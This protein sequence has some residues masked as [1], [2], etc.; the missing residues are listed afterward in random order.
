[1]AAGVRSLKKL[2]CECHYMGLQL[3]R[4]QFV[5]LQDHGN[6]CRGADGGSKT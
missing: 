3:I 6:G 5:S 4:I 2:Y 1:M